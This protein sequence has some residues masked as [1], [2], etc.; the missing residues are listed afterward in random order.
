MSVTFNPISG[1]FDEVELPL[2]IDTSIPTLTVNGDIH[3]VYIGGKAYLYWQ[4][5]GLT[6][7]AQATAG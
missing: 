3:I 6:Y 1:G 2:K 7:Y 4:S 5:N